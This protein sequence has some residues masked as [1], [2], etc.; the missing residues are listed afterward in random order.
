M[1][2]EHIARFRFYAEL[3]DF[4]PSARHHQLFDHAFNGAPAIKDTIEALGVPHTEVDLIL[5]NGISVGFDY[6]LQDGDAV[7]VY[8]VFEGLD[9]SG[10]TRLRPLPA[11]HTAFILD[12]HLGKLA[13]LLRMAGFDCS[14]D[15][16]LDDATIISIARQEHRIILTRDIGLLKHSAVSHGYW[17]RSLA[18]VEQAREVLQRYNL[19][20]QVEPFRRC[21]VCNDLVEPV[22]REAAAARLPSY[23]MATQNAIFGC[24]S[25]HRLYWK[26]THYGRMRE[27]LARILEPAP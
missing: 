18:P 26:G 7:S 10:V 8:P 21:L 13:R 15:N 27:T 25:C 2:T 17:V 11:C 22:P 16:S 3:N 14:Y 24:P 6:H 4:L 9:V 19:W 1:N 5:V 23:V 12:V 20:H